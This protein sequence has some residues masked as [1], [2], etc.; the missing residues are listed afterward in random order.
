MKRVFRNSL[1]LFYLIPATA[2]LFG[3]RE[4]YDALIKIQ[5][6]PSIDARIQLGEEF[7][8]KYPKS[9]YAGN[10]HQQLVYAYNQ[11]KNPDKVIEHG[12]AASSIKDPIM[13]TFLASAYGD[14]G[15]NDKSLETAQAA[16]QLLNSPEAPSSLSPEQKNQLLSVNQYL[17]GAAYYR[18]G[19]EK[20]GDEK[21]ALL[22]K[23]KES[24]ET[25][26]KSNPKNDVAYYQLGLTL[27]ERSQGTAA[28]EALAK[29]VV[30]EGPA[31]PYAQ[32]DLEK[33][34]M[35]YNNKSKRGLDKL[36]AKAKADLK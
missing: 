17:V 23:A 34:Y 6:E 14:K 1:L 26:V 9:T 13:S 31:K 21:D 18:Q 11:K 5:Q 20:K 30:L 28:C 19:R 22:M 24:L 7:L 15:T 4:E 29:A 36:L 10:V 12:D 35:H 25:A 3:Q 2:V 32:Q 27:A 16:I 33:I 8:Q